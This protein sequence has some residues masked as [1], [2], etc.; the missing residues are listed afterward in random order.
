MTVTDVFEYL[1][2]GMTPDE[3]GAEFPN[4]TL[5]DIRACLA[6]VAHRERRLKVVSHP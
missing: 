1:E 6:F 3:I 5:E 4:L 2:S